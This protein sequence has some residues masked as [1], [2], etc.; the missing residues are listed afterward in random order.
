MSEVGPDV[1]L[2]R[3]RCEHATSGRRTVAR[4]VMLRGLCVVLFA[5]AS[6]TVGSMVPAATTIA[7]VG[8]STASD[9]GGQSISVTVPRLVFVAPRWLPVRLFVVE[10]SDATELAADGVVDCSLIVD[11]AD[12]GCLLRRPDGTVWFFVLAS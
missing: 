11:V 1:S 12:E 3:T 4:V 10:Y 7:E 6:V 8:T 5:V 9:S 2:V